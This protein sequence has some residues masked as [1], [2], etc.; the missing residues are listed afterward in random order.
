MFLLFDLIV[1][2]NLIT[3]REE[4]EKEKGR[5]KQNRAFKTYKAKLKV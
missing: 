3:Q 2:C 1:F 4:E 5:E